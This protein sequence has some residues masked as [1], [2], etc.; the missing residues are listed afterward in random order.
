MSSLVS[1]R[2]NKLVNYKDS[3]VEKAGSHFR[4]NLPHPSTPQ[5]HHRLVNK[6]CN[7]P[8]QLR[9]TN[10]VSPRSQPHRGL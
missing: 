1:F 10:R 7:H 6:L 2:P 9:L 5:C 8:L 4:F 3:K